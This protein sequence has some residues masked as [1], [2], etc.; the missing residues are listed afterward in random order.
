MMNVNLL[1]NPSSTMKVCFRMAQ[2][3]K[4]QNKAW[5]LERGRSRKPVGGKNS[6]RNHMIHLVFIDMKNVRVKSGQ[7]EV[8]MIK[9]NIQSTNNKKPFI[10]MPKIKTQSKVNMV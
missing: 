5:N 7:K 2:I 6:L 10:I 3:E 1:E 9:A 4:L 8:K